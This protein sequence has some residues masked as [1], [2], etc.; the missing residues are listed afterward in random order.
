MVFFPRQ[1]EI[2]ENEGFTPEN[3]IFEYEPYGR[4]MMKLMELVEDPLVVAFEGPGGSGK[5]TFI[6]QWRGMLNSHG[7]PTIYYDAFENDYTQDVFSSLAG[8][9]YSLAGEYDISK[10][11]VNRFSRCALP[12]AK[13]MMWTTL[14]VAAKIGTL[15]ALNDSEFKMLKDCKEDIANGVSDIVDSI[16][17]ERIENNKKE[18]ALIDKFKCILQEL[19]ENMTKD[20]D[21]KKP[22]I[23]IIDEL[24]RC[25][26]DF[27][28]SILENI[29]HLFSVRGVH[30]VLVT[31]IEQLSESIK[32]VYGTKY[33]EVY[34][35][36]FYNLCI[37]IYSFKTSTNNAYFKY[38]ERILLN[39]NYDARKYDN[40]IIESVDI[41]KSI[42][43]V[44]KL[45]LR[46]IEKIATYISICLSTRH[47]ICPKYPHLV[48]TLAVI[49][50]LDVNLYNKAVQ[51][52]LLPDDI[53]TFLSVNKYNGHLLNDIFIQFK[54]FI[55]YSPQTDMNAFV[56][57]YGYRT[58]GGDPKEVIPFICNVMDLYDF[59]E[60]VD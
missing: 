60:T 7:F 45:S 15:N 12:V 38:I 59:I 30:F 31:N 52:T 6:K 3:D 56:E 40:F 55:E 23:F 26:P 54:D 4:R 37:N 57:K 21:T 29:K 27:A 46:A 44:K 33:P 14:K 36:K 41:L 47:S 58:Y 43:I 1:I 5:S 34:L 35:H 50:T 2:G 51:K 28:L 19:I 39:M 49:K 9:V 20:A 22:L 18:K 48:C 53:G 17:K 42:A 8:E 13:K 10:N 16:I 32:V 25:R 24:D 11:I